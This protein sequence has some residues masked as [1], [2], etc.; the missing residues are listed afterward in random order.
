[1]SIVEV[2]DYYITC[3]SSCL[4]FEVSHTPHCK[5]CHVY[6]R[7]LNDILNDNIPK[8][9]NLLMGVEEYVEDEISK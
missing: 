5:P 7:T 4:P 9:K 2:I 8:A 1:M 6:F 3:N